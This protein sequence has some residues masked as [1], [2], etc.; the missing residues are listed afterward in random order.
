MNKPKISISGYKVV[1]TNCDGDAARDLAEQRFREIE[2]RVA[3]I[4]AER[5]AL[6]RERHVL[7]RWLKG[8][9]KP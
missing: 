2:K 5:T 6:N 3:D 7:A 4:K 1:A 9:L 8:A